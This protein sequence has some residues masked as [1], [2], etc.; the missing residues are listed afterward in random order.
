[1]GRVESIDEISILRLRIG[2]VSK[3]H[4]RIR[5]LRRHRLKKRIKTNVAVMHHIVMEIGD[6]AQAD[7]ALQSPNRG[8]REG[9]QC[10]RERSG[11]HNFQKSAAARFRGGETRV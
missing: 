4:E 8:D 11:T 9:R 10:E 2:E 1:M 6:D 3:L 7:R 5:L